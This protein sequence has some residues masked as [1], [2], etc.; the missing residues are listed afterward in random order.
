LPAKNPDFSFGKTKKKFKQRNP[1]KSENP[2]FFLANKRLLSLFGKNTVSNSK[3]AFT[4]GV[5]DISVESPNTIV[6]I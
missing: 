4:L 3:G 1:S 2:Y 5:R 6:V